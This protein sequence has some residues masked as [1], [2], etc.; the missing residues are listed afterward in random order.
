MTSP[1]DI[2]DNPAEFVKLYILVM[3]VNIFAF[4]ESWCHMSKNGCNTEKTIFN[5][6]ST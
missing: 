6:E 1:W 3:A 5:F 4:L 2:F